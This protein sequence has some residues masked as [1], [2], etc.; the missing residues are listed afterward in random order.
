MESVMNLLPLYLG[1]LMA[2]VLLVGL[3]V[4]IP[5]GVVGTIGALVLVAAMV[6][7][8][9]FP[10][11][12]GLLSAIAILAGCAGG[13]YWWARVF[14]HTRAG[15]RFSLERD[16]RDFRSDRPE[17]Q[18]LVGKTGRTVTAL[19]PSGVAQI[20]GRRVDVTTTSAWLDS[21]VDVRV[22]AVRG[23]RVIV[24]AASAPGA[25]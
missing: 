2:G 16:G 1:L 7:G 23:L 11:P 20:D 18:A 12:Y 22:T 15:R 5:G 24:E 19:R 14:P 4:Y 8:F 10:A 9:R 17:W 3:E 21:G 25:P 13:I 6:V